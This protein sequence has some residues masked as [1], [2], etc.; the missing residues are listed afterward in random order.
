MLKVDVA[1]PSE[2]DKRNVQGQCDRCDLESR[3]QL[4]AGEGKPLEKL[5]TVPD[6]HD[7]RGDE[8]AEH[9]HVPP[10]IGERHVSVPR[11]GLGEPI[12]THMKRTNVDYLIFCPRWRRSELRVGW[13]RSIRS[14]PGSGG[15]LRFIRKSVSCPTMDWCGRRDSNPHALTGRRF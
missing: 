6:E 4:A 14:F 9:Q 1:A 2:Q 12:T 11:R 7:D 15:G 8:D 3:A 10:R 13:P 5:A